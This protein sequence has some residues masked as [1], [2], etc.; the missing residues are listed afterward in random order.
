MPSSR[1]PSGADGSDDVDGLSTLLGGDASPSDGY[2]PRAAE[3]ASALPSR[4]SIRHARAKPRP[5]VTAVGVAGELLLT[6]GL[7]LLMFVGWKYWLNDLIVGNEQNS[8]GASVE[9]SF[10]RDDAESSAPEST[11]DPEIGIPV[12]IAPTVTN[13]RFAVLYVPAW[14]A[15]Y[16]RP[17]AE[18]TGYHEVL[19]QNVGHYEDTQMPGAVGNFAIAG[20]R[21]A[22]GASMQHIHELQL[23][24]EIII[25][26]KD[27]WYTYT[28]RSGE[29]VAPTQIDVLNPIPRVPTGEESGGTLGLNEDEQSADA[30]AVPTPPAGLGTDRILTLMSC[31]PFWS[32]AERI[33]AYATFA[34]FTPRADGPPEQIAQA[35]ANG[36]G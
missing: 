15:D 34:H 22:Y 10:S 1:T 11:V 17:I 2:E 21:L 30:P 33:I 32:T 27:G 12:G 9:E 26:T 29:Y 36:G 18:G 20:H 16:S 23:G 8:V 6:M 24:D 35:V 25:G 4:R 7:V 28:Y 13:E 31:N 3:P 14:G 5:K 19:N